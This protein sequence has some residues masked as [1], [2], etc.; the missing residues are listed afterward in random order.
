MAKGER[1]I[2]RRIRSV[3]N[4][5]QITR[6]MKMVAS[7]KLQKSQGRTKA[8]Q[9]YAMTLT[10]LVDHLVLRVPDLEHPFLRPPAPDVRRIMLIVFTS[11]KGLCG[12]FNANLV[13]RA[14]QF[15]REHPEQEFEFLTIGRYATRY[16]S[17]RGYNIRK[18]LPAYDYATQFL[19]LMPLFELVEGAYR[20][21]EV[22]QVWVLYSHF[23]STV[24]QQPTMLQLL[25]L[26]HAGLVEQ[27]GE[28]ELAEMREE[29]AEQPE[30]D[31]IFEP[32]PLRVLE[33]LLPRFVRYS[34]YQAMRE[35]FTSENAA[36]MLAMDNATKN[37]G[38]MIDTLTLQ[39]NKSRQQGITSE[40]LDIVGGAEA[41]K[42]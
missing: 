13:R 41:Q 26:E 27:V 32:S 2:R 20:S 21:G 28:E 12:A 10:R 36:R 29:A 34:L 40:L 15:V 17:R 39:Y 8:A 38:E 1:E 33:I 4:T 30:A 18:S 19:R 35:N 9:P 5:Q 22:A 7:A 23:I 3:G 11:D 6:A 37:A 25:P 14:E 16:F 42:G 31:L 24:R